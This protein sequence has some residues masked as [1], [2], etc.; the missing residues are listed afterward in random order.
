MGKSCLKE[1][2]FAVSGKYNCPV[3]TL[4]QQSIVIELNVNDK[5]EV[6]LH[7]LRLNCI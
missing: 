6:Q 5:T 3:M 4:W 2:L 1:M 7:L